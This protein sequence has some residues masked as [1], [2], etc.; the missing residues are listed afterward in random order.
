[1][2]KPL[3]MV[4]EDETIV[5]RGIQLALGNLGYET[6][7]AARTGEQAVAR[8]LAEKPD[9]V[10]M[11]ISL[12][13]EMDGV[14]AAQ[15]IRASSDI[16]II[17]LTAYA[18]DEK[19][20]RSKRSDPFGYIIKPFDERELKVALETGL[21]KARMER[22]LKESEAKYRLIVE[23][24]NDLVVKFDP[25]GHLLF[26]TPS[27][28]ETFG[29]KESELIGKRFMPLIHEDDRKRVAESIASLKNPPHTTYHESRAMTVKGWRWFGWSIRAVLDEQSAIVENIS[30]GRDVTEMK[31][32]EEQ[33]RQ[34]QK[35]EAIGTL[36]GGI[37]HNFNNILSSI[38]GFTELSMDEVKKGS[39]LH[40]NLNEVFMAGIRARDQ[41]RQILTFSR[42]SDQKTAP[43]DMGTVIKE[44]TALLRASIPTTVQMETEIPEKNF[45]IEGNT[46]QIH[47]VIINLCT[48][49]AQA[50]EKAGGRLA[51]IL[52]RVELE[53]NDN[54]A[55]ATSGKYVLLTVSDT[56]CGMAPDVM[57]RIF[58]PYFTTRKTGKGSG[59]GLALVHGIVTSHN[60]HMDVESSEG[61]GTVFR[62][63]LPLLDQPE[64][65]SKSLN[66]NEPP[67]GH[68]HILVVDDEPQIVSFQKQVL[69]GLGYR[70]KAETDSMAALAAFRSAPGTFDALVTDMTMPGMTGEG[71]ARELRKI[72]PDIPII[73]CTGYSASI[74][75]E[76]AMKK[77]INAFLLKPVNRGD[78]AVTLRKVL[79][80]QNSGAGVASG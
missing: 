48:N 67:V 51:V 5:S 29:R 13:G 37:A 39:G 50:M 47:Q 73:L 69:E 7:P 64:G 41:V 35:M 53:V 54:A 59:M 9:L 60:G 42:Q 25:E 15:Q 11:D 10:L 36:A 44:A 8:A 56:G 26:V 70:V 45:I 55:G 74:S 75:E 52:E 2:A 80:R 12:K 6:S 30:V 65:N 32:L 28:C 4:V 14:E 71:L 49:A 27:Y 43:M 79:E 58:D 78:L 21:H 40:D 34:A 66:G 24:Q 3:I 46:T 1:M 22:R 61:K 17:F 68:E 77:G 19:I 20:E 16:P 62:L 31:Q 63:Y 38:L 72:R 33:L 57:E 18:D 76:K 23:N